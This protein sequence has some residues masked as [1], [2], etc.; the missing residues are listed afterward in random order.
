MSDED[1]EDPL[2]EGPLL[3]EDAL[4]ENVGAVLVEEEN[5]IIESDNPV[6]DGHDT[7]VISDD[8]ILPQIAD[9]GD[10]NDAND[11]IMQRVLAEDISSTSDDSD[12]NVPLSVRFR[13]SRRRRST[14]GRG[15]SR[16]RSGSWGRGIRRP[17]RGRSLGCVRSRDLSRSRSPLPDDGGDGDSDGGDGDDGDDLKMN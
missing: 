10:D 9:F 6:D 17:R 7:P 5:V 8:K 1:I 16:S 2:V 13:A 14:R 12:D 11:T 15:S 4:G 3:H